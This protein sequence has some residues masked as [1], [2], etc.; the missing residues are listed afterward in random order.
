MRIFFTISCI[1][2]LN[3]YRV[4]IWSVFQDLNQL[5]GIYSDRWESFVS[6][7][8]VVQV[9]TPNDETTAKYFSDK[10]GPYTGVST[11][12]SSGT[13]V[14]AGPHGGVSSNSGTSSGPAPVPFMSVQDF[15]NMPDWQSVLFVRG[16][17][18]PVPAFKSPYWQQSTLAGL[19]LPNPYHD[20]EGFKRAWRDRPV[21]LG[22]PLAEAREAGRPFSLLRT[23]DDDAQALPA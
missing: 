13:S 21:L 16:S 9:F 18:D 22:D 10:I 5:Q 14:S 4:R 19:A 8:G 2:L 17:D 3:G 15:Y 23:V 20:A 7:A 11:S 1:A 6:N 12:F